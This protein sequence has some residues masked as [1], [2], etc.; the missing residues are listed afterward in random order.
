METSEGFPAIARC[1][2]RVLVLGSLPGQKSLLENEYYAHP[3]NAFWPIMNEIFGI[4]GEYAVRCQAL[5]EHKV[6]VW[7]VLQASV[8]PGSLD[9]DIQLAT[10]SAND[11]AAFF[12]EF[13]LLELIVFNGK[14]AE[15]LF[16]QF[17]PANVG[18][19]IRRLGLPSTSPAHAA[20]SFSQKLRR[21]QVGFAL[22]R[23]TRKEQQ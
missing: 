8:R 14:K 6:A 16:R 19:T 20:M 11:F 3:R 9:A 13:S 2:A 15:Q 18:S 22:L 10:A 5:C 7:D 23:D 17:V 21:W 1:D 4:S 12:N